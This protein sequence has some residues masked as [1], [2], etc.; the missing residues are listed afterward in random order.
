[1]RVL[2]TD[3]QAQVCA[4]L[5]R[6]LEQESELSVVGEA[7]GA[8]DLLAQAKKTHPDLVLLDWELPG[9]P[10]VVVLSALRELGYPL[11]VVALGKSEE[12]CRAAMAAGADASVSRKEPREWLLNTLR[13]VGGL[14]PCFL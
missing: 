5:R 3:E 9:P 7:V 6:F 4:A 8:A 14:S 12:M 13:Q 11:K 10:A 1:M 2:L